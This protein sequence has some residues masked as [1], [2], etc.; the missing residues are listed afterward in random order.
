LS[1]IINL[2]KGH[3]HAQKQN[4]KSLVACSGRRRQYS[5]ALCGK[6]VTPIL[7]SAAANASVMARPMPQLPAWIR[8]VEPGLAAIL[9]QHA[10][11]SFVGKG[12][13]AWSVRCPSSNHLQQLR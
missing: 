1:E 12:G 10:R 6:S 4:G 7:A 3:G 2:R 13:K 11:R 9:W 5:K 8:N